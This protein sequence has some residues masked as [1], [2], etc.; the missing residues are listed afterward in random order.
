ML[1]KR[2]LS[3]F[4][5]LCMVA[6]MLPAMT[7]TVQAATNG[8]T[9]AEAVQWVRA[10]ADEHWEINDGSGWTQCT[11]FVWAYYE[12]L[13]GYH[14]GGNAYEYL[15][16]ANGACPSGWTRPDKSTVQPGDIVIW[17]QNASFNAIRSDYALQYG[18]IGVVVSV[19]GNSMVTAEAN[20]YGSTRGAVMYKYDREVS[21]ISGIIR[22]DWPPSQ[23]TPPTL[24]LGDDFY[25]GIQYVAG[26]A[27]IEAVGGDGSTYTDVK[28]GSY[29]TSTHTYDPRQIWHFIRHTDDGGSYK[30]I[31]EYSGWCMDVWGGSAF[32]ECNVA[33]WHV[34]H[35]GNPQ[36]WV[37]FPD[38]KEQFYNLTSSTSFPNYCLDIFRGYG[39]P[40][41]NVQIFRREGWVSSIFN[42]KKEPYYVK[43]AKP[44]TPTFRN[45]SANPDRT[46]LSWNAVSPI[47]A[48]DSREY[49]LEIYDTTNNKYVLR[50]QHVTGTSY[51]TTLPMGNYRAEIQAVNT[52]YPD[53]KSGWNMNGYFTVYPFRTVMLTASPAEGGIVVGGGIYTQGDYTTL[54]AK[55]N[56]GWR[57][58][59]WTQNG[60][61]VTD[62]IDDGSGIA[63]YGLTVTSDESF[64][65]LFEEENLPTPTYAISVSTAEG[66]TV[67]GG[68]NYKAG[69]AVTVSA[70]PSV[71]YEF[72]SWTEGNT[73]VS[74]AA[75]Y[76]FDAEANRQL[77]AI[78]EKTSPVMHTV[79]VNAAPADGGTVT[80]GGYYE[81][82]SSATVIATP[83]SG[84]KFV[85][86]AEG[87]IEA[88][89]TVA[90]T[91]TVDA[92]HQL[93]AVFEQEQE[94]PTPPENYT[95]SVSANLTTGGIVSGGRS[96]PSGSTA[97][98][99]AIANDGYHFKEWRENGI[100][101]STNA[102][103]EFVVGANRALIAVFEQNT[104]TTY[105][106]L[107]DANPEAGGM[108]R[109]GGSYT[110][111]SSVTVTA[112]PASGYQFVKWQ[113]NGIE[114][115]ENSSYHFELQK[116][117]TL[118][119]VFEKNEMPSA[120]YTVAL[121]AT[122][123]GTVSGSGSYAPGSS[124]TVNATPAQGYHFVEW[125]ENGVIVCDSL[126]YSFNIDADRNLRAI[127]FPDT[128]DQTIRYTVEVV[129]APTE[130]GSVS[131]G[132]TYDE[133]AEVTVT[134]TAKEGYHFLHWVADG[135]EKSTNEKYTFAA[136]ESLKLTAV[137][138]KQ[139]DTPTPPTPSTYTVSVSAS[140]AAG[141]SV[142][143]G[144]SYQSGTPVTVTAAA[145]TGYRFTGWTEN[146]SQVSTNTSYTF[147][148][149]ANRALVAGFTYTGSSSGNTS[150][151]NHSGS[152]SG[153]TTTTSIPVSTSGT[154][155]GGMVTTAAPNATIK[156][157]AATSVITTAIS[158]EIIKQAVANKS[159]EV[160]ISPIIKAGTTKAE[161][162]IPADTLREI[163]RKTG[164]S[165]VV[166]TPIADVRLPNTGLSELSAKQPISIVTEKVGDV[167][168]LSITAGGSPVKAQDRIMLVAP[169]AHSTPGMVAALVQ[170]DGTRQI[171]RK[172]VADAQAIMVPLEGSAKLVIIDNAKHFVDVPA[173]SWAANAVAFAS[174][175]ELFNGTGVNT[176]SPDLPMTRGMLAVVLHNLESN[177][178][179]AFAEKFSDVAVDAWYADAVIWAAE[180][181]IVS[182]YGNGQFDP[183][184][185]IT[186][187]QL[188]V[189]LWRYAGSPVAT[190]KEL[191][192]TDTG[193]AS[194][195]ALEALCWA[196]ENG[197]ISGYGDGR[198]GPQ[199][200]A[201][202]AQVAQM[203]MNYL[204]K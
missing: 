31:N 73:V 20:A 163:E 109:G 89:Q 70:T 12:Y 57:F 40:G 14:V 7:P 121:N 19:S 154:S 61:T 87:D 2:L 111:G 36:R 178:K 60:Q 93:T 130:G 184:N 10:R 47:N 194:G 91:F 55:P 196:V 27:Y 100:S 66:G 75:V 34:D 58:A 72:K 176:F 108:V 125:Q 174:A 32:N 98:V 114:V 156:D 146:G 105:T 29:T 88:S 83:A 171:I 160:V 135:E 59:G 126:L 157:N 173:E 46:V 145:N 185:N 41:T 78:F 1:K 166:S 90:Y 44:A 21:C 96:Y 51:T 136:H 37:I 142:S 84:Y 16:N 177:P 30:I 131:G 48:Y 153:S 6:G 54:Q 64:Q 193:E 190:D 24:N 201:T 5:C 179:Q 23:P 137:F 149:N 199:E 79:N 26:N 116:N 161:I 71:G 182:G 107:V 63:N 203:L 192:F 45:I 150:G 170:D 172:S 183:G 115:S 141:G 80:G 158:N 101:V 94:A 132:G 169:L 140:P 68:G 187:E 86:W 3:A 103:Y 49:I 120:S 197:I 65:A 13:L 124:V 186:R 167:L 11:E 118:T 147:T 155:S 168:A 119:A 113:E 104:P 69:L 127:F 112:I 188:A 67:S 52:K 143:G 122:Q 202:R 195:Y 164:A 175:H 129:A 144:G 180:H 151:G 159:S 204:K 99:T 148:A 74:N 139:S 200:L 102:T 43:P 181:G 117:R 8:H 22:P 191:H 92:D 76:T 25:A 81:T 162:T 35:D 95:I 189:M 42:I 9:Q 82:G 106:V 97:A 165:L 50:G 18:H 39:D 138:E 152:S 15:S 133:S 128:P 110:V 134:A 62:W 53:Y 38:E 123:G 77:V 198:L 33:T 17:A 4:L 85:K 56:P 28:L